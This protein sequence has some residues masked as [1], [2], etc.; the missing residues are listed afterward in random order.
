MSST[1]GLHR[2]NDDLLLGDDDRKLAAVQYPTILHVLDYPELRSNFQFYDAPANRAKSESRRAGIFAIVLG[3]LALMGVSAELLVEPDTLVSKSLA[4]VSAAA[5]IAG[6][7]IGGVGVLFAGR[8]REWLQRRFVGERLRQFHFQTFTCRLS[9]ILASLKDDLAK[10]A[11]E[12]ARN[13]WLDDLKARF[14]HKLS[15]EFTKTLDD[16]ES[17]HIWL[18]EERNDLHDIRISKDDP[19]FDA[20]RKLRIE[21]QIDYANYHLNK[22]D[23]RIFSDAPHRQAA[24]IST[25]GFICLVL[26]CAIHAGL[27]TGIFGAWIGVVDWAPIKPGLLN[28]II[29]WLGT[30]ALAVRAVEQGLQPERE[31]DRYL[32]YRSALQAIRERFENARSAKEKIRIMREME[33]LSFDEM[34]NFLLTHESAHFVM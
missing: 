1:S 18:H 6:V 9:E 12:Q 31:F 14:D 27:L 25:V 4:V 20:Y 28:V 15:A 21:H 29:I 5:G 22:S 30:V 2:F 8:K 26:F 7:L 16:D 33:R 19:L 13:Q 17:S 10:A 23:H 24:V 32:Q 34:R 3:S 11:F